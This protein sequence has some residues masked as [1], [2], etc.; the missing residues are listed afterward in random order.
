MFKTENTG[1]GK[2]LSCRYFHY[3]TI[4][5]YT[6]LC[7]TIHK[8]TCQIQYITLYSPGSIS[9]TLQ[10]PL[11][12][13]ATCST[14]DPA[15]KC[16]LTPVQSSPIHTTVPCIVARDCVKCTPSTGALVTSTSTFS[17]VK[18]SPSR[19][20]CAPTR[21]CRMYFPRE[22]IVSLSFLC[23]NYKL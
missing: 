12:T 13:S 8:Y 4:H 17:G 11:C 7:T 9:P 18:R 3:T 6:Q 16:T 1:S 19:S 23:D 2:E 5:D 21:A 15:V 10:I 14:P 20:S 22:E